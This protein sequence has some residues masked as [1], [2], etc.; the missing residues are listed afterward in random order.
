MQEGDLRKLTPSQLQ[1]ALHERSLAKIGLDPFQAVELADLL[2][3]IRKLLEPDKLYVQRFAGLKRNTNKEDPLD[4]HYVQRCLIEWTEQHESVLDLLR[5]ADE[6]SK[7]TE[8]CTLL[9]RGQEDS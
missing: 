1:D 2:E 3:K 4:C 5:L 6:L 9:E 8:K 7:F